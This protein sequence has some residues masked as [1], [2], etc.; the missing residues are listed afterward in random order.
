MKEQ[1]ISLIT[2]QLAKLKGFDWEC[3]GYYCPPRKQ[4]NK[5]TEHYGYF[6]SNKFQFYIDDK[7]IKREVEMYSAPTQSFLQTWLRKKGIW[8]EVQLIDTLTEI[9]QYQIFTTGN[10]TR[11][12]TGLFDNYEQALEAGLLEALNLLDDKS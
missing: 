4:G 7:G 1:E 9:C 8:V 2:S 6:N 12:S 11:K 3:R 5:Y 10:A